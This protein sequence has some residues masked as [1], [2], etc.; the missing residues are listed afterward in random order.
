MSWAEL[1]S[2]KLRLGSSDLWSEAM[3]IEYTGLGRILFVAS[4]TCSISKR[5]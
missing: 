5:R 4:D 2:G 1:I 3:P